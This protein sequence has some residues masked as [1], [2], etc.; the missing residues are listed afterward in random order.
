MLN[1]EWEYGPFG[2]DADKG[3]TL[4]YQRT[5]LVVVNNITSGTRLGDIVPQ[6]ESDRRVQVMFTRAPWAL[7][8][9]GVGQFL[10]RLGGVVVPWHQATQARFD[11][12]VA[13]SYGLLEQLHAPVLTMSHGAG[14]NKY[15]IRYDGST[16]QAPLEMSGLERAELVRRGR[17]IPSSIVVPTTRDL[18]WLKHSCPE[19]VPVAVVAGDPCYDRLLVSLPLRDAYRQA[20]DV[21]GRK[22]VAVSSSWGSGSLLERCPDLISRLVSE[23]PREEYRVAAI[24]HPNTWSWHGRRQVLAWYAES[25][26]RGLMLVPPEEGWRG[27][28]AAA[29]VVVGDHG[30]TTYYGACTG[31][32]V[33]LATFAYEDVEPGSPVASLGRL[34]PRLRLDQPIAPQLET[35]TADW[36]PGTSEAIRA[37]VTDAPG[38]SARIIRSVMYRLM[39]LP[40]PATEPEV[41]PV[42][43]PEPIVIPESFGGSQ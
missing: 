36:P 20:L 42:P 12:A 25:V 32:P 24:V 13:A 35:A 29:D 6:L 26:R 2:L 19:A 30:S 38:Q 3:Q 37:Q 31:V 4:P 18:T 14:F 28:L 34:A 40:E 15:A 33:L 17:V 10:E 5:A 7:V 8:S 16:P 9:G 27:V 23:L 21:R 11:L 1:G 43:L 41:R 39:K 22:L